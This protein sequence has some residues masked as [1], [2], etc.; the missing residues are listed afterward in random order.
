MDESELET[1]RRARLAEM[2]QSGG[3]AKGEQQASQEEDMRASMLSQVLS[4]EA[5]ERLSRI[6]IVRGDRARRYII[7]IQ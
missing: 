6:R 7:E 3:D 4:N 2:K 1:I 5:R